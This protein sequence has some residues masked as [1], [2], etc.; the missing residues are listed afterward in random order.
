M[1]W[2]QAIE[3]LGC[4]MPPAPRGLLHEIEARLEVWKDDVMEPAYKV[5]MCAA[6]PDRGGDVERAK[7]VNNAR[8]ALRGMHVAA[9][10]PPMQP[11]WGGGIVIILSDGGGFGGGGATTTSWGPSFRR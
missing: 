5:A 7:A 2:E 9:P 4:G 1:T 11:V 10:P 8:D 3:V 6:H